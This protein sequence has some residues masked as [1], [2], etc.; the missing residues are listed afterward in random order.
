MVRS[1]RARVVVLAGTTLLV[2]ATAATPAGS[3]TRSPQP[4]PVTLQTWAWVYGKQFRQ[5]ASDIASLESANPGR[6]AGSVSARAVLD[7]TGARF[8]RPPSGDVTAW[9]ALTSRMAT[10]AKELPKTKSRSAKS[11]VRQDRVALESSL[12]LFVHPFFAHGLTVGGFA[13]TGDLTAFVRAGPGPAAVTTPSAN[14]SPTSTSTSTTVAAPPTTVTTT[15]PPTTAAP[16]GCYPLTD[17][18][19]C[20]RAGEFCPDSDHQVT[21]R[22]GNGEAIICE[23]DNGWRWEPA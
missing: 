22:A 12:D 11:K 6:T 16:A 19:S 17:F 15:A 18:A 20:Y 2:F 3:S 14:A 10:V 8:L 13:S 23:D 5:L 21:G 4:K 7:A 9:S 1:V